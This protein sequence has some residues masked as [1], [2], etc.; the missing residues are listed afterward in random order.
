[1]LLVTPLPVATPPLPKG[2]MPLRE[3]KLPREIRPL[4]ESMP[5]RVFHYSSFMRMRSANF[6]DNSC[7]TQLK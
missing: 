5:L 2:T 3:T 7:V 4:G 6:D 1:M